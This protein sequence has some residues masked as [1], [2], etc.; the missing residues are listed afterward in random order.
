MLYVCE[1][2]GTSKEEKWSSGR[3][4]SLKCSRSFSTRSKR[5]EVNSKVSMNLR[6]KKSPRPRPSLEFVKLICKNCQT[7]FMNL[8][9]RKFCSKSCVSSYTAK[10]R[11][12]NNTWSGWM[13]LPRGSSYA[14][15]YFEDFFNEEKIEYEREKKIGKYFID[16]LFGKKILEVDGKQHNSEDHLKRD[17]EKDEFL[18]SMG[19][20]VFR[21]KWQNV[22]KEDGRKSVHS[23]AQ[24]FL[25]WLK[26]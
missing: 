22:N 10:S 17:L 2:C 6:G 5:T 16:F 26:E 23:Q 18:R 21:I 4:C 8:H 11:L 14:E 19:Y 24:E 3:F 1:N 20:E 9:F 25:K 15:K 13:N 7:E 12:E